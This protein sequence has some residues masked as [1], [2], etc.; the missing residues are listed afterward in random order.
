MLEQKQQQ[1]QLVEKHEI[2]ERQQQRR[3]RLAVVVA[4]LDRAADVAAA[5]CQLLRQ[6]RF[7]PLQL[8]LAC[9]EA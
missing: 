8:H 2:A 5:G 3:R 1:R 9:E 7:G 4:V 6:R